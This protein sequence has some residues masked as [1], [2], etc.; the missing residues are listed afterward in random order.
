MK[1][2][3]VILV[4]SMM[5][6]TTIY[7]HINSRRLQMLIHALESQNTS[8]IIT[9]KGR[10]NI[11]Q[12]SSCLQS[13]TFTFLFPH[14]KD[15]AITNEEFL[16]QLTTI[17]HASPIHLMNTHKEKNFIELDALFNGPKPI[18]V[19]FYLVN[20]NGSYKIDEIKNLC[21]V[22]KRVNLWHQNIAAKENEEN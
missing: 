20:E 7:T 14:A 9:D 1:Y 6:V 10:K 19:T 16:K 8:G 4:S 2:T 22:F 17:I 12:A 18:V 5:V 21:E 11:A 13:N 3:L 15:K